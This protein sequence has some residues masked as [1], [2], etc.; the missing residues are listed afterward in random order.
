MG[1]NKNNNDLLFK[2]NDAVCSFIN[3]CFVVVSMSNICMF[4]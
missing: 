2:S 4:L 3:F 1:I